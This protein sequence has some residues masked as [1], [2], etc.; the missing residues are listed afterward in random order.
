MIWRRWT[1]GLL[2][3]CL[4][5]APLA[6]NA[7]EEQLQRRLEQLE[8]QQKKMNEEMRLLREE[9]DKAKAA[10]PAPTAAPP[11]PVVAPVPAAPAKPAEQVEVQEIQRRQGIL[12]D[13]VRRLREML[14]LPENKQLKSYYGLGPAASKVYAIDRGLS[15]GGY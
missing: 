13:E 14:V 4:V 9:L 10:A 7:D 11:V 12:T 5:A 6:A 1:V 15:I 2:C 3:A 8:E